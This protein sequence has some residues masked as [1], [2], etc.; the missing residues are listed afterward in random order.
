MKPFLLRAL[1]ATLIAAGGP[2]A[3]AE[4]DP[5]ADGSRGIRPQAVDRI[6]EDPFAAQPRGFEKP[7]EEALDPESPPSI[8]RVQVEFIELPLASY[9][10][11]LAGPHTSTNDGA[12]RQQVALLV[13]KGAATIAETMVCAAP[14]RQKGRT[15]SITE[16]I[17]ATEYEPPE[18][19]G[20][21]VETI[22]G[23]LPNQPPTQ[24]VEISPRDEHTG[25]TP[26][27]WD[28]R[29][30]GSTL[31]IEPNF[32]EDTG[33]IRLRLYAEI[34]HHVRNWIWTEWV[35]PHGSSPIQM[36]VL[37]TLRCDLSTMVVPG[38]YQVVA[39]LTP[40]DPD[41]VPDATRKVMVFVK[42]GMQSAATPRD[43]AKDGS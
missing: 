10:A 43:G 26:S 27:A 11:L 32:E 4:E 40:Q 41:G 1:T 33:V 5:F 21:V 35:G 29:N 28:T 13:A 25:P 17:Y 31:E 9:T 7:Q 23:T 22:P 36:P 12:L 39:A 14:S 8:I 30:L 3:A 16:F 15:E 18:M 2:W 24:V 6:Q 38:E 20:I 42:C 19:S 34:V 37:Y